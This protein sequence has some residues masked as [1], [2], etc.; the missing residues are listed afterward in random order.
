MTAAT[1]K[2]APTGAPAVDR[3][4]EL[5]AVRAALLNITRDRDLEVALAEVEDRLAAELSR[6]RKGVAG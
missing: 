3:T 2:G 6:R 4:A 5:R 1:I